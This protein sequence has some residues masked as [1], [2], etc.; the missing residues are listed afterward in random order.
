MGR[1]APTP[2]KRKGPSKPEK[3]VISLF[4][5]GAATEPE[6][7][8]ALARLPA[9]RETTKLDLRIDLTGAVPI[10]LVKQAILAKERGSANEYWCVFDV[11]WPDQHPHLADAIALAANKKIP[12]AVSNPAFELWL[13]L[14]HKD[15]QAHLD[16]QQA[17]QER[18]L[19]DGSTDKHL[20]PAKYLPLRAVAAARAEQLRIRHAR[21]GSSSPHDN[22]SSNVYH[23]V[24]AI[25]RS[26]AT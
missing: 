25:E 2:L 8:Q 21:N 12:I 18:R 3:Y 1:K 14:H 4:C 16:T 15:H 13:L 19:V 20:D 5:E 23:L 10:T 9:V 6:Y 11:E 26:S 17:I 22:P 24:A 7:F